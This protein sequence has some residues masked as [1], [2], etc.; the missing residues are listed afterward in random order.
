MH[1][2]LVSHGEA[3]STVDTCLCNVERRPSFLAVIAFSRPKFSPKRNAR[4]AGG[5][6]FSVLGATQ[7]LAGFQKLYSAWRPTQILSFWRNIANMKI[8]AVWAFVD[9]QAVF[10]ASTA[11][12]LS[13]IKRRIFKFTQALGLFVSGICH[14]FP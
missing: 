7:N 11:N 4:Q 12:H 8:I 14:A 3:L 5:V 6:R 10:P 2:H 1:G 13:S 9:C